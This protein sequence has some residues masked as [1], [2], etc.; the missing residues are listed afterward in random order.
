MGPILVLKI[1]KSESYFTKIAKKKIKNKKNK[2]AVFEEEK[3][4][5]VCLNLQKQNKKL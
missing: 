5:E 1:I 3:P 2:M 4:L